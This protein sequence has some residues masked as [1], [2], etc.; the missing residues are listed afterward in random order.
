[1]QSPNSWTPWFN[2]QACNHVSMNRCRNWWLYRRMLATLNRILRIFW[3]KSTMNFSKMTI[4]LTPSPNLMSTNWTLVAHLSMAFYSTYKAMQINSKKRSQN[5]KPHKSRKYFTTSSIGHCHWLW[6]AMRWVQ[7][8]CFSSSFFSIVVD[9]NWISVI[10]NIM[11]MLH[12]CFFFCLFIVSVWCLHKN[13]AESD[14][15]FADCN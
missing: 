13:V 10:I 7:F 15:P 9:D 14:W 6:T 1:M 3:P 8:V 2:C 4:I 11:H 12:K 5:Q